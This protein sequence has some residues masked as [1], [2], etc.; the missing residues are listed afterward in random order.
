VIAVDTVPGK[1]ALAATFGATDGVLA[2]DDPVA[3][4]REL[5]PGGV[6]YA[7]EVIGVPAVVRQVFEMTR[8]GGTAVMVGSPATGADI[9][10]DGRL[11]FADRRLL[12]CMGGGNI[13]HRDI[14]RIIELYRNGRIKLDE[15]ISQRLPLERVN[16]AFAAIHQGEV[17]RS[18][19]TLSSPNGS[20]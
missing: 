5:V 11:L 17:A 12:G 14:P 18:I 10:I 4:V 15:L 20:R 19:V 7:F 13:P 2:G 9:C 3:Q 1:V 6:D 8:E 16:D